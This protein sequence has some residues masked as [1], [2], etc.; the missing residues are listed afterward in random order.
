M[1]AEFLTSRQVIDELE[2][3]LHIKERYSRPE[4]DWWARFDASQPMEKFVDY[5]RHMVTAE[6][7]QLTGT[8]IARVKAFTPDDAYLIATTMVSLSEELVNKIGSRAREDAVRYAEQE[9]TRARDHLNVIRTALKKYRDKEGVIDPGSN[10]V[11]SNNTLA[12]TLRTTL[13]QYQTDLATMRQQNLQPDAPTVVALQSRIL[14]TQQQLTQVEAQIGTAPR[15]SQSLSG[16]VEEFEKLDLDRQV[17]QTI[18][19]DSIQALEQARASAAIKHLYVIPF[20]RPA[21]PESSTYPKRFVSI[22][23]VLLGAF[24]LWTIGVLV[25]RSMRE[26]LA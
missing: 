3:R 1:V 5:W 21:R 14:A 13:M 11:A 25:F 24:F 15:G 12:Q 22:L 7:D 4:V 20:V 23:T 8:A 9:V 10:V 6:F 16:V 18:L 26:H 17:A 2:T 19:T